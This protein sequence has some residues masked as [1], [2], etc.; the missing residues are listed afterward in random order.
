M[1]AVR[2]LYDAIGGERCQP[3]NALQVLD[4]SEAR[5]M[6]SKMFGGKDVCYEGDPIKEHFS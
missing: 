1:E 5:L 6:Q 4:P 2:A 3:A